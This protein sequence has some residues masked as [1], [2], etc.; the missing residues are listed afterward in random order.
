MKSVILFRTDDN[1][2]EYQIANSIWKNDLYRFRTSIPSNSIVIG[3]YSVLPFY[4]EL[5]D[6][7]RINNSRLINMH[8]QHLF[9]SKMQY[10]NMIKSYT[11]ETWF[12]KGYQ[13]VPDSNTGWIVKGETNSKKFQWNT[14]MFASNRDELKQVMNNLLEDSFISSQNLIIRKYVPLVKL[15]EGLNGL[16]FTKEYRLFYYKNQ[17]ID[18][19]FYW[20]NMENAH[21]YNKV[22]NEALSIGNKVSNILSKYVNFYVID[23]AETQSGE[24]IV[25]EVND[26]QM[27]GLSMINPT[28][29]Y[30][31]LK[32]KAL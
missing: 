19:S 16:Q 30:I 3:R 6:E 9:I 14:H 31:N 1:Q 12:N 21:K 8:E 10:Y 2:Q 17:Y 29:F 5:E 28:N 13:N 27:S 22:P 24:W 23:V 20:S 26:G 18:G 25:I 15:D 4:Q 32:E 7:L 11:P